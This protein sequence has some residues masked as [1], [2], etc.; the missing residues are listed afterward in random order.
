ML[1]VIYEMWQN[2]LW[3]NYQRYT[4]TYDSN[5]KQ[6]ISLDEKWENED[7]VNSSRYTNTYNPNGYTVTMLCETWVN[8]QW[9]NSDVDL[10]FQ[11]SKG[12]DFS[13]YGYKIE[14][15]Y[16][17]ASPVKEETNN[18]S[19]S[20]SSSPNPASGFIKINYS[21][22]EPQNV[23]LVITNSLGIEFLRINNEQIQEPG[24]YSLDYDTSSLAPGVYF[25]TL[26][27]GNKTDTKKFVII[28]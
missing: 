23:S 15:T 21:L 26:K 7:W 16:Q 22:I 1:N 27:A 18:S 20:L 12:I 19:L 9:T 8:G 25:L 2:G 11:D 13:F 6:L 24:I 14:V 10:Y 17:G 4:Y 28:R 3:V 5:G